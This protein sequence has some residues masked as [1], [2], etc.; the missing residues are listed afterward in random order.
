MHRDIPTLEDWPDD[1]APGERVVITEEPAGAPVS[2]TVTR[3]AFVA[4]DSEA[5]RLAAERFDMQERMTHVFAGNA[6]PITV[7]AILAPDA[8]TLTVVDIY[9]GEVTNGRWLD[10]A[11]QADPATGAEGANEL[12]AACTALAL[13]GAPVL[14]RGPFTHE[15]LEECAAGRTVI[16]KPERERLHPE[17][18]PVVV[19]YVGKKEENA[20]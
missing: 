15:A 7:V 2:F 16:V 3:G 17:L 9:I 18:G 6:A 11:A 12:D 10:A 20:C 5:A 4:G 13:P 19:R 1:F 8:A 14:F